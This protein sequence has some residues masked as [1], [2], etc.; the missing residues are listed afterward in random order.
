[1]RTHTLRPRITVARSEHQQLLALAVSG[2]GGAAD[3]LWD[4]MERAHVVAD[5]KLPTD[6]VRMGSR[7]RYRTDKDEDLEVVL[8]FPV[9]ADISVGKISVLT[10]VGAALIGLRTGQSITWEARD[11]RRHALTVLA[12]HQQNDEPVEVE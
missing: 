5:P 2:N 11:G 7:V 1:M 6:V 10:P 8:V 12:V 9:A 4:E 3:S